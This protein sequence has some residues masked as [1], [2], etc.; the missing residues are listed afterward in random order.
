MK[1]I[2]IILVLSQFLFAQK[3]K[4]KIDTDDVDFISYKVSHGETVKMIASKFMV[5]PS[6][7]YAINDDALKGVTS[8]MILFF[9]LKKP[10]LTKVEEQI[11]KRRELKMR[12]RVIDSLSYIAQTRVF[13]MTE[14]VVQEG[15]T[16]ESLSQKFGITARL[17]K[18]QNIEQGDVLI[19]GETI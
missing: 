3:Q 5:H 4:E 13:T 9:P 17:I 2:I 6:I 16:Y 8:G 12:D 18:N 15:D 10:Q 7:I 1:G 19:E 14:Y 11:K